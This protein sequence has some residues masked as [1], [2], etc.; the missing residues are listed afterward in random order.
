MSNRHS[1]LMTIKRI[2]WMI[3]LIASLTAVV[4]L[5]SANALELPQDALVLL[6]EAAAEPC[7]ICAEQERKKA[8]AILNRSFIP[9]MMLVTDADCRLLKG[10]GS[11]DMELSL[12]CYPPVNGMK[13]LPEG[14][15]PVHLRFRFHTAAQH[16]VGISAKDFTAAAIVDTYL[17]SA[18]GT[19]FEGRLRIIPYPYGDGPAFNYFP[20]SNTLQ[21]HCMIEELRI[22]SHPSVNRSAPPPAV[23]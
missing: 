15:A 17:A 8:F 4:S 9:G 23:P 16:L 19:I 21:I 11:R 12:T 10:E 5:P 22:K 20:Q 3:I 6:S 13:S 2:L 14:A 7:A 1:I 18:P